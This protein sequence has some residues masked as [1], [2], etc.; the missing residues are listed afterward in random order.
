MAYLN[1]DI[2]Y[3]DHPKTKHLVHL[4][5]KGSEVLPLKLWVYTARYFADSG[6]LTGISTQEIEDECRW[7]G[8]SGEMVNAMTCDKSKFL[9]RKGE[10]LVVHDWNEHEG[11][12][13]AFK[14]R[15]RSAALKRWGKEGDTSNATSIHPSIA[16]GIAPTVPTNQPTNVARE[17]S[18]EEDGGNGVG[19][20]DLDREVR[21]YIAGH[22]MLSWDRQTH[23]KLRKLVECGGWSDAKRL[24]QDGIAHG[25]AFPVGWALV[26]L[27]RQQARQ[28]AKP[29]NT[30]KYGKTHS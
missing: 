12:I 11:H 2:D 10:T 21:N 25:A 18:P 16:T 14:Q 30:V 23:S 15:A 7:W 5:G 13:H 20:D 27:G 4:L 6:I 9:E 26:T 22:S 29:K 1:L 8:Q 24:I 3:F 28:N 19:G 17:A